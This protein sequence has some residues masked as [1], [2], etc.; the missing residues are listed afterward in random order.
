MADDFP[1]IDGVQVLVPPPEGYVVDFANPQTNAV[2][3]HYLVF[4][5]G[6][7]LALVALLQ[8]YYTKIFLSKGLQVDDGAC[9]S[10][11]PPAPD[12]CVGR[13]TNPCGEI[14]LTFLVP[15]ASSFY[16]A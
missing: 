12:G 14:W 1:V 7:T 16:A 2:L 5:I 13:W 3:Q 6:G 11:L 4:G 9:F 15:G 10:L 8:R